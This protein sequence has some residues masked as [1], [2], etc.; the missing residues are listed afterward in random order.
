MNNTLAAHK[1]PAWLS[2]EGAD[3]DVVLSTRVRLGRNL[4]H[5][6]FTRAASLFERASVFGQVASALKASEKYGLFNCV[7]FINLDNKDQQF[8]VEERLASSALA[9]SEGERGVFL[10]QDLRLSIMVNEEDH[11]TL[12]GLDAG[13]RPQELWA[14]LDVIDDDLGT[15]L[16]FAFDSRRGFLTCRPANAGTGLSVSFLLHLPGLVLTRSVDGVLA[17]AVPADV[18]GGRA[19]TAG[20]LF[21][22]SENAA[23]GSVEGEFLEN[24][25]S[26]VQRL[27][28]HERAAREKLL[29]DARQKLTDNIYGAWNLA[30]RAAVLD[31]TEYLNLA[32]VMRLGIECNLFD[33]CT[34]Q[35]L[36]RCTLFV[37]P[38]RLERFFGRAMD[39]IEMHAARADMVRTLLTQTARKETHSEDN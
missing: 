3:T 20:N 2:T 24:A 19:E 18:S 36:N 4:A 35:D 28:A 7:N 33:K 5:H 23:M 38:A 1:P 14:M 26:A 8:L 11:I 27:V 17:G 13:L 25:R 15:R 32:S 29:A 6:T 16:D 21:A 37:L 22:V 31:V 34:I 30:C 9:A 39:E 12:H 10:D